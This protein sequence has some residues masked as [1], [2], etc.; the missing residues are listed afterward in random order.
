MDIPGPAGSQY[1]GYSLTVL[2]NGNFVVTDPGWDNFKGAVYLYDGAT[3]AQISVLAG[4][5]EGDSLGFG[6]ITVLTTGNYVVSSPGWNHE[7][8]AATWCD[9]TTGLT[10]EVSAAN[11]WTGATPGDRV[12]SGGIT[13][14]K[15]GDYVISS[16]AWSAN[17]GAVTWGNGAGGSVG[18]VSTANSLTGS[19]ANDRIGSSGIQALSGNAYMVNSP[20]WNEGRGAVT[21]GS[22]MLAASVA[23][24]NSLT[25]GAAGDS[26]GSAGVTLLTNGNYVV[27]SPAG[28]TQLSRMPARP[29]LAAAVACRVPLQTLIRW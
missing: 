25:G 17:R 6:G 11:S 14:L 15:N 8:G 10:A 20:S 3:H 28:I 23:A 21:R 5:T 24:S 18:V 22:G 16:M 1:F 2:P 4:T 27:G 13:A 7:L 19:H 9:Q 29:P 26:V 12:S